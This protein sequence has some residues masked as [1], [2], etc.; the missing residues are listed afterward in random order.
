MPF[1]DPK[2]L[3]EKEIFPGIKIRVSWGDKTMMSEEYKG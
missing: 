3:A 1:I 2:N